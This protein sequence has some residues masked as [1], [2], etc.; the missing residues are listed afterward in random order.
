MSISR[1]IKE[2]NCVVLISSSFCFL[3]DV[4]SKEI[5]RRGTKRGGYT[6]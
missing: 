5:I 2:L 6:T 1:D 4:L 3:Q